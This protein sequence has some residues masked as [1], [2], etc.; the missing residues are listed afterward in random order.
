MSEKEIL[1]RVPV[2]RRQHKPPPG[3]NNE[4]FKKDD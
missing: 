1:I 3:E 2:R 4:S